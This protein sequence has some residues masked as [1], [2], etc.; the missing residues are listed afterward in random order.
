MKKKKAKRS[1]KPFAL[2]YYKKWE[3]CGIRRKSDHK[4]V[5]S[6]GGKYTGR[7]EA[8]LR[9]IGQLVLERLGAGKSIEEVKEWAKKR[10]ETSVDTD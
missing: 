5:F 7:T 3:V 2:M 4:Q 9:S 6:F 1:A 10:A 8:E